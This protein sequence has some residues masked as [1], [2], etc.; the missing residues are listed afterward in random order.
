MFMKPFVYHD[1]LRSQ[2]LI[3][4]VYRQ[5]SDLRTM[6]IE[7]QRI[8]MPIHFVRRIRIFRLLLGIVE[9]QEQDYLEPNSLFGI[10]IWLHQKEE[11]LVE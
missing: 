6:G 3:N 10:D 2:E 1:Q 7:P 4:E 11:I 9:N 8:F 5:I